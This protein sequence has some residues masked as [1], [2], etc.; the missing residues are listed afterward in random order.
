IRVRRWGHSWGA[1]SLGAAAPGHIVCRNMTQ[2]PATSPT[3]KRS[4]VLRPEGTAMP[5]AVAMRKG[6]ASKKV[7]ATELIGEPP[8]LDLETC[9]LFGDLQ[10]SPRASY[11]GRL[12]S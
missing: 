3:T 12:V 4:A 11:L 2:R 8:R 10:A 6:A 9:G 1:A 7:V 5:S